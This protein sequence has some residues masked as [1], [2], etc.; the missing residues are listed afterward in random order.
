M[1]LALPPSVQF[2][3]SGSP[4]TRLDVSARDRRTRRPGDAWCVAGPPI[5]L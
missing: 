3:H 5:M 4:D 2:D 1:A